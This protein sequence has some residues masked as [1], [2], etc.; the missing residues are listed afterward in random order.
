MFHSYEEALNWIHSR[1]RFGIKPGL[2]RME[3]M[4]EKLNHPEKQIK[5]VHIGGTNGKGST[6]TYLRN[7]LQQAGLS[8]GTFTSPYI[9]QFNERISVNGKPISDEEI[10]T[11][12]NKL[13][14]IVEEMDKME[15]GGPTEFEIITAMSFYYFAYMHKMDIVIYEVGLGGRFDS[16]NI[17]SP[18]LSIITSIGLDHTAILGDTYEQ[19]AF[20]KAGIIKKDTPIIAAVKQKEAQA[21]IVKQAN[22]MEAPIYLLDKDFTIAGYHSKSTT[23]SFNLMSPFFKWEDLQITMFGKHQIENASLAVIGA[24][25]L[26]DQ[27]VSINDESIRKGL[28]L[29]RWPGRFE[30][31]SEEP[32]VV[33]DGAH[34]EE[35]IEALVDVLVN[36]YKGKKKKIIF[37][38]LSDKKTDKM[39][40]KLDQVASTITFVTFDYPRAAD[41]RTLY[42]ESN[43]P[44]K[45]QNTDWKKAILEHME[46]IEKD[47]MLL[48]TGSLYFISEVKTFWKNFKK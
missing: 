29:S 43:H 46:N 19:I 39:I 28:L 26:R 7:I 18:L 38:A 48:I 37:A 31:I 36:R 5:T 33:L 22:K 35:G 4:M 44:F 11:L 15:I 32:L 17:I 16:T 21:V 30:I 9:E 24:E 2:T 41:C 45:Y 13:H 3:M 47:E 27:F 12:A 34:N 25:H 20:E 8:V 6:V 10:L 14:P 23:E 42:K 1:L 40:T